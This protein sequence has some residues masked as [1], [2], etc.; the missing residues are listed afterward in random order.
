MNPD[1]LKLLMNQ[2]EQQPLQPLQSIQ[3]APQTQQ[4]MTAGIS[5][6]FSPQRRM[7]I[8]MLMGAGQAVQGT[9]G[10]GQ[11]LSRGLGGAAQAGIKRIDQNRQNQMFSPLVKDLMGENYIGGD[12][13]L[14]T[15]KALT[16][17]Q[18]KKALAEKYANMPM[19]S[20]MFGGSKDP[21]LSA[22]EF[23]ND[24]EKFN[25]LSPEMQQELKN[26]VQSRAKGFGYTYGTSAA[27]ASGGL[28]GETG[29]PG[30]TVRDKKREETIGS[31]LLTETPT[32]KLAPI[33][34]SDKYIQQQQDL[35]KSEN[36]ADFMLKAIDDVLNDEKGLD[37][38]V[39]GPGGIVGGYAE[40]SKD[41]KL[42]RSEDLR[43]MQPKINQLLGKSFLTAYETLKG[44]GQITEIEG[45]KATDAIA[46]LDQSQSVEDF[47][48]ALKDLKQVVQTA[49]N[50]NR[51]AYG[52][53]QQPRPNTP[54]QPQKTVDPIEA[55]MRR[56]G[57]L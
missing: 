4:P 45:K 40:F 54:A 49:R 3:P 50:R 6:G 13:D 30:A 35:G 7:V 52:A 51:N 42:P 57:L 16:D 26:F 39:G 14:D 36:N 48:Q 2:Q 34:G 33:P 53:T 11:A 21:F 1:F 55:E 41:K 28:Y 12:V 10:M 20:T 31:D 37:A 29:I 32:G 5:G 47:K 46:R 23:L 44:G 15:V 56:R 9:G 27:D 19:G 18:Y 17:L 8:D 38:A 25:S 22:F 24:P 43:R